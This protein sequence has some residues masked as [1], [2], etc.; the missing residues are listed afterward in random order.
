LPRELAGESITA[1]YRT[2]LATSAVASLAGFPQI[3]IPILRAGELPIG[4]GAI[5]AQ[6]RDRALLAFA[7]SHLTQGER[8]TGDTL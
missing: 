6:G 5:A 8:S 4:L 7:S 2:A 1:F 3:S